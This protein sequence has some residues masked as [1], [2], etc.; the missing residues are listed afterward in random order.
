[1]T[2]NVQYTVEQR[3]LLR[4]SHCFRLAL[5][6]YTCSSNRQSELKVIHVNALTSLPRLKNVIFRCH[7]V[8]QKNS[9]CT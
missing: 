8:M 6:H 2:A 7:Y 5:I 3:R 1:M 4:I 9:S